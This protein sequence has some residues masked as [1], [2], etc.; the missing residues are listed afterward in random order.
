MK[1][2][3]VN[4][5]KNLM[6][7]QIKNHQMGFFIKGLQDNKDITDNIPYKYFAEVQAMT[8]KQ[9]N[10]DHRAFLIHKQQNLIKR[11]EPYLT[12]KQQAMLTKIKNNNIIGDWDVKSKSFTG[13]FEA[14]D[15]ALDIFNNDPSEKNMEE[16]C[17]VAT[18]ILDNHSF[19]L[20]DQVQEVLA[21]YRKDTE[22]KILKGPKGN[23]QYVNLFKEVNTLITENSDQLYE[24]YQGMLASTTSSKDITFNAKQNELKKIFTQKL[25]GILNIPNNQTD[26]V[27]SS[28]EYK[29]FI[30]LCCV[31][32]DRIALDNFEQYLKNLINRRYDEV[33]EEKIEDQREKQ[34]IKICKTLLLI[35]E[36][37]TRIW[38][39]LFKSLDDLGLLSEEMQIS[40]LKT[41]GAD[42]KKFVAEKG[43]ILNQKLINID[44]IQ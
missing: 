29:T 11:A 10:Q 23:R 1:L 7:E 20:A 21:T 39:S 26:Q 35:W 18:T 2:K 31:L 14:F 34:F 24:F 5:I 37:F 12:K 15:N 27:K 44:I 3:I 32:S 40:N 43:H 28:D 17:C 25:T 22:V 6:Y 19:P 33:L 36:F 30:N 4:Q 13:R 38:K 9:A 42:W 41:S 16:L 8:V